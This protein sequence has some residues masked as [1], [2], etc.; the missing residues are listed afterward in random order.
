MTHTFA[1]AT[2]VAAG[3]APAAFA[4]R[5]VSLVYVQSLAAPPDRVMP[6]L[7]PDGERA[8]EEDWDPTVLYAAPAPGVGTVFTTRHPGRPPTVWFLEEYDTAHHRVRYV[9][10]TPGSDVTQLDIALAPVGADRTTATVR[11]TYTGFSDEGNAFVATMTPEHYEHRLRAWETALN[12][13]LTT[14]E[15]HRAGGH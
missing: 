3:C 12:H 5:Q 13:F 8:W 7:T 11:Y 2:A 14:G 4:P 6:L 15:L 1:L 10:M 9:R